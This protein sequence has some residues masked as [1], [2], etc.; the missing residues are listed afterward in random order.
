MN[1]TELTDRL[2]EKGQLTKTRASEAVDAVF[3]VLSEALRRGEK[4]QIVGFGN[5]TVRERKARKGRNPKTGE[6]LDLP[7]SRTVGFKGAKALL[8]QLG[9][10][11]KETVTATAMATEKVTGKVTDNVTSKTTETEKEAEAPARSE[12]PAAATDDAPAEDPG[13]RQHARARVEI[14]VEY[15]LLDK[16]I[17]DYTRNISQGGLFIR[18]ERLLE[19]GTELSFKLNVP[20]L[21]EPLEVKGRVAWVRTAEQAER[22]AKEPGMG[23]QFVYDSDEDRQLVERTVRDLIEDR[24]P[25]AS[26]EDEADTRRTHPR[27]P[28]ELRV[29]YSDLDVFITEYTQNI[30]KGGVFIRSD[31]QLDPGT[32]LLFKLHVPKLMEPLD[33]RGRVAWVRG[34]DQATEAKRPGMGI[35][36]IYDSDEERER[37]ERTVEFLDRQREV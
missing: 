28:V 1:K 25:A 34:G 5:F 3:G 8:D 23:V 13:R 36:F 19:R 9:E 29:E 2:A 4:I 27:L 32:E 7:A 17:S 11:P 30:S 21:D 20:R 16:F 33:L 31:H 37:L 15:F 26:V 18:S 6:E 22:E 35:R 10:P 24:A 14:E 12:T